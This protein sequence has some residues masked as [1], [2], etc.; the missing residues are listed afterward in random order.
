[1]WDN[2]DFG[3]FFLYSLINYASTK[4]YVKNMKLKT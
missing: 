1:M 4:N 2:V 3:F